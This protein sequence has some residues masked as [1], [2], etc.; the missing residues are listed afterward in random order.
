MTTKPELELGRHQLP[1]VVA[2]AL[3]AVM[4]AI[5]LTA[6][7]GDPAGFGGIQS[8]TEGIGYA[9]FNIGAETVPP[10]TEGFLA[11]FEMIALV[12][13]AALVAGVMLARREVE[14]EVVTALRSE[15]DRRWGP[16]GTDEG[17]DRQ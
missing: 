13:T 6:S 11:L 17:G 4:A 10:G 7:F 8:V 2:L 14:G 15:V 9:L 16:E 3:F 12:L 5:I 1:G